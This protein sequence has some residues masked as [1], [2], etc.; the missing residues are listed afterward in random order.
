MAEPRKPKIDP[1]GDETPAPRTRTT[2]APRAA[3]T[4]RAPSV[5]T[6]LYEEV[7]ELR[8][9][10]A[11]HANDGDA[12][13][14]TG[15]R[16]HG[17]ADEALDD[18]KFVLARKDGEQI[19]SVPKSEDNVLVPKSV[20]AAATTPSNATRRSSNGL[21]WF[22]LG[23]LA[24]LVAALL[25][26][27]IDWKSG[28][29]PAPAPII[30]KENDNK[31]QQPLDQGLQRQIDSLKANKAEK[32]DLGK[33]DQEVGS[34]VGQVGVLGKTV[35]GLGTR[36]TALESAPKP[37]EE[38]CVS[39]VR[40]VVP[41]PRPRP[42]Y[43][44]APAP[45]KLMTPDE[46]SK[47]TDDYIVRDTPLPPAVR[48]VA[49]YGVEPPVYDNGVYQ[50]EY[51]VEQPQANMPDEYCK[52]CDMFKRGGGSG[53]YHK[54]VPRPVIV[55]RWHQETSYPSGSGT[56]CFWALNRRP[57]AMVLHEGSGPA[58]AGSHGL[59]SWN[60]EPGAW[61]RSPYYPGFYTRQICMPAEVLTSYSIVSLCGDVG[62]QNF[63]QDDGVIGQIVAAGSSPEDDPACI[64]GHQCPAHLQ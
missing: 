12:I 8:E 57:T 33:T 58:N 30:H 15:R 50:Q 54:P 35:D 59:I 36:V 48:P 52:V 37:C 20:L 61:K 53:Y 10:R 34:L 26:R 19:M 63:R 4:E 49:D 7:R 25:I 22:L 24:V 31:Q 3:T 43:L 27:N 17:M 39:G 2:A 11:R 41:I 16:V 28:F 44:A 55:P 14:E 46:D 40:D 64:A 56:V 9:E 51:V 23:I 1:V 21:M 38:A 42:E 13:R 6:Q 18:Y 60:V 29:S 47:Y 45:E 5:S 32:S 62:Y